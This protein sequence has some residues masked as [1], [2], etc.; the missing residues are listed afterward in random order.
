MSS[1]RA[2]H[3]S[4]VAAAATAAG[5]PTPGPAPASAFQPAPLN[6]MRAPSLESPLLRSRSGCVFSHC[7]AAT[8]GCAGMFSASCAP[9]HDRTAFS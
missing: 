5:M 3:N 4:L 7:A 9:S 8:K 2:V 6:T 1:P